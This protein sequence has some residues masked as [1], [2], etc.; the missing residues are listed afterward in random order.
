MQF[1]GAYFC[2]NYLHLNNSVIAV[3]KVDNRRVVLRDRGRR[4][5]QDDDDPPEV[6]VRKLMRFRRGNHDSW[7]NRKSRE[8]MR[9]AD[10]GHFDHIMGSIGMSGLC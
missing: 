5:A 4:R 3:E 9:L 10:E 8:F 6:F 7:T 2:S 1:N